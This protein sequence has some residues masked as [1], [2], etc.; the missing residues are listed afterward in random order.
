MY[1]PVVVI[2]NEY[3]RKFIYYISSLNSSHFKSGTIPFSEDRINCSIFFLAICSSTRLSRN[4]IVSWEESTKWKTLSIF[5]E[6]YW[7]EVYLLEEDNVNMCS[8]SVVLNKYRITGNDIG[9]SFVLMYDINST[10]DLHI[11]NVLLSFSSS[12]SLC[13]PWNKQCINSSY[14]IHFRNLELSKLGSS[15]SQSRIMIASLVL[16]LLI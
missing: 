3:W 1:N 15:L 14:L 7:V 12:C 16:F 13:H 5:Q 9:I 4:D 6:D 8:F 10:V 11:V 2:S